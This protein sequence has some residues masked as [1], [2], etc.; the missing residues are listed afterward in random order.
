MS[1]ISLRIPARSCAFARCLGVEAHIIEPAGFPTSDRAFRRCR[2]GLPRPGRD[3][4]PCELGSVR[5][6]ARA[7]PGSR[8]IL[9][10]TQ[11]SLS[12][13]DHAYR[14]DDILLFGRESAGVPNAVHEAADARLL[15]PDAPR[16]ALAQCGDGRRHGGRGGA[17]A[18]AAEAA[19]LDISQAPRDATQDPTDEVVGQLRQRKSN[20]KADVVFVTRWHPT[21]PRCR[22]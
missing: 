15:D 6:L 22:P 19:A 16:A 13:L 5:A 2:H 4:A 7:E 8:L 11:A 1:R 12:Y 3:R 9:F 14:A 17:A 20:A 10:T 21:H 18:D